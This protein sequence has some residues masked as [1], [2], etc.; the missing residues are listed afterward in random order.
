MNRLDE[1][2]AVYELAVEETEREFKTALNTMIERIRNSFRANYG[3][4]EKGFKGLAGLT[5]ETVG[6]GEMFY[7]TLLFFTDGTFTTVD[8]EGWGDRYYLDS[9]EDKLLGS[10]RLRETLEER[11]LIP[12]EL[13]EYYVS[14]EKAFRDAQQVHGRFKQYVYYKREF[15]G[16]GVE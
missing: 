2:L 8:S 13:I 1:Q 12:K 9:D 3:S 16:V 7:P 10:P 5:I 6:E 4:A 11:G 15:E 14:A